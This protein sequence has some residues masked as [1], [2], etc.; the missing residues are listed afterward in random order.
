MLR[1]ILFWRLALFC[2]FFQLAGPRGLG[3]EVQTQ[4]DP[5]KSA[6]QLDQKFLES[7]PGFTKEAIGEL[8]RS[9]IILSSLLFLCAVLLVAGLYFFRDTN[10]DDLKKA[11]PLRRGKD[12]TPWRVEKDQLTERYRLDE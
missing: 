3:Q 7:H 9:A 10:L 6:K 8:R 4:T 5:I 1:A 2:L 12:F 11:I